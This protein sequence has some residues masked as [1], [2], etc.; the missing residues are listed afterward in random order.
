[1]SANG[2]AASPGDDEVVEFQTT[3]TNEF[4][5]VRVRKIR[6]GNGE[7]LEIESLRLPHSIRLDALVLESLTWRSVLELG[8]GLE[9]PLGPEVERGGGEPRP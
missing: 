4:T 5:S 6:T 8:R 7:R 9:T 3:V 1:V 2:D